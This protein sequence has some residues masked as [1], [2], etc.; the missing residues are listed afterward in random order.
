VVRASYDLCFVDMAGILDAPT[1]KGLISVDLVVVPTIP[2]MVDLAATRTFVEAL[3]KADAKTL[4]VLNS[5]PTRAS[6]TETIACHL[7]ALKLPLATTRVHSRRVF[8]RAFALSKAVVEVEPSGV[9]ATEVQDL[10]REVI[11][12]AK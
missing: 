11:K 4:I 1:L 8:F 10:L 5:C 3:Q 7:L 9:A 6:E 2:T 12:Y